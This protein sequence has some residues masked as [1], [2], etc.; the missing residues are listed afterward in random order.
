MRPDNIPIGQFRF[1]KYIGIDLGT[2]NTYIYECGSLRQIPQPLTLPDISDSRGS[3]ATVVLYEDGAPI[4]A[5]NVAEAEYFS[6]PSLQSRRFLA[7]Q[8]KPE[9]GLAVPAALSAATDFLKLIRKALKPE[10]FEKDLIVTVGIP[11]LA[12]EDFRL[13]LRECFIN[14][15]WPQP[16]F[17]RESDA[18][19]VSCLQSGSLEVDDLNRKCLILDFGGGTCDY[20][21]IEHLDALE[22]GGDILYGGRLFDDLVYQAFCRADPLFA[23]ESPRS[24][25]SWHAHWLE[26]REQKEHLSDFINKNPDK[27]D[28]LRIT[29]HDRD[30]KAHAAYLQDYGREQFLQDAE[31]YK[32]SPELLGLLK[33]Y[34]NRGGLSPMAR[35]LLEG[36]NVGLIEWLRAILNNVESRRDV[37]RIILTGG[38]CRWFFVPEIA[39]RLFP[40]AAILPSSRGYEDIAFGLAL[41][42]ML[43]ESRQKALALLNEKL[44]Q[45]TS[46]AITKTSEI[47]QNQT[48]HIIE[49]C[50]DRMVARDIMPAL[51]TAQ[52][53]KMTATELEEEFSKNI[54]EDKGLLDIVKENSEVLHKKLSGEL[55]FEFRKWLREN[56]V[57][58]APRFDFPA[59]AIGQNFFDNISIR[60]SRL[61]SLNIMSFTMQNVLPLLAA[62]ATAGALAHTGE[63]VST[64]LGGGAAFGATWIIA[65]TAPSFLEQKKLP[66]F[67]LTEKNRIKIAE[68]NR[69][70]I[71]EALAKTMAETAEK[72]EMDIKLRLHD[73]LE[74]MLASLTALNQIRLK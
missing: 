26:C 21:A 66:S 59:Q 2:T 48:R 40:V 34:A 56:G 27:A 35:D 53:E 12:R 29:W 64:I 61:D 57:P 13:N 51:E 41:F 44:P 16:G 67:I 69:A 42:P 32:A 25:Y 60:I 36:R 7:N 55:N 52:H 50:A 22:A 72:I 9:I 19:L 3:I 11:S 6:Q 23:R 68:K 38:S 5:G 30:G 15:G 4:L 54:R 28:S 8:F 33:P 37:S 49:A 58:L 70:H 46:Q 45:F 17:V 24:P 18:A 43:E 14:A 10:W 71:E 1:M 31:N 47:V 39:K 65:K 73:S 74:S 63:P 62:T 20:T